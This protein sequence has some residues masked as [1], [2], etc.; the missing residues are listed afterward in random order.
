MTLLA[1][2]KQIL[3]C[4]LFYTSC[5]RIYEAKMPPN[6]VNHSDWRTL[7]CEIL[8]LTRE[9][10]GRDDVIRSARVWPHGAD[11]RFQIL[12]PE[13]FKACAWFGRRA[14]DSSIPV[15]RQY[16][17]PTITFMDVIEQECPIAPSYVVQ[18][19]VTLAARI[20]LDRITPYTTKPSAECFF[21][22]HQEEFIH[23]L[24]SSE[25]QSL[26]HVYVKSLAEDLIEMEREDIEMHAVALRQRYD[27]SSLLCDRF[28]VFPHVCLRCGVVDCEGKAGCEWYF[29]EANIHKSMKAAVIEQRESRIGNAP[30]ACRV[31]RRTRRTCLLCSNKSSRCGFCGLCCASP[32][33]TVSHRRAR[34]SPVPALAVTCICEFCNAAPSVFCDCCEF[35]CRNVVCSHHGGKVKTEV[36]HC[37]V[38]TDSMFENMFPD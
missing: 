13:G 17:E 33:C 22:Q 19:L 21:C 4:T 24:E 2:L 15:F 25:W 12:P 6:T 29:G 1:L 38:Q 11:K 10:L 23:L 20:V 7:P 18:D 35:C 32:E 26:L 36:K 30:C 28:D 16:E 14:L 34:F 5:P 8:H 3:A 37:L 27:N 9:H 31:L